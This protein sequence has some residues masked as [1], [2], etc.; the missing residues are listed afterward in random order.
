MSRRA[1]T[2]NAADPRQVRNA[3]RLEK[4]REQRWEAALRAVMSTPQGRAFVWMLIRRAGIYESPFD[5]H[6]SIQSFKIGRADMGREV[7][8][9][10][11]RLAGDEYLVMEAEA[12]TID[13]IEARAVEAAHTAA[14]G[15]EA[16]E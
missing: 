6:G 15:N 14:A 8:G 13:T 5:P 16:E 11:L 10:V 12:R 3:E 9:E 4:R 2:Q 7:M 1:V